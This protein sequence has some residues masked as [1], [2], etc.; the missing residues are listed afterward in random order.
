MIKII[1]C[2]LCKTKIPNTGINICI[3]CI[4]KELNKLTFTSQDIKELNKLYIL[5]NK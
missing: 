5:N 3:S 4:L 1:K 2:K